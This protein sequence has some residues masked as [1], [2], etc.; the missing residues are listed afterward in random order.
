VNFKSFPRRAAIYFVRWLITRIAFVDH[1][2]YMKLYVV[3]LRRLGYNLT[4]TPRYISGKV[5]IDGTD[6]SLITIGDDVVIS[7]DVRILTHDFSVARID[8]ALSARNGETIDK[9]D[10][11]S[12]V[13]SVS[14]GNNSFVGA[15]SLL[16]PGSLIGRDCI[17]GAGSVVR[18]RIPD[19]SVVLGNPGRI[20]RSVY[21]DLAGDEPGG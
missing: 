1:R 15:F 19:G 17:I 5:R 3:F 21:P 18:G 9:D 14:I 6:P 13:A 20:I 16:M 7:S 4:G 12:K 8:R 11:R 10:E 2:W